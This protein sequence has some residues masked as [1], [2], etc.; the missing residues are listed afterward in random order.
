MSRA[1]SY[2]YISRTGLPVVLKVVMSCRRLACLLQVGE[3][4]LPLLTCGL[5]FCS[6]GLSTELFLLFNMC[7][8]AVS[9]ASQMRKKR[10]MMI[11]QNVK[12]SAQPVSSLS[13]IDPT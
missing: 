11:C 13:L 10:P 1:A 2:V 8:S 3:S 6:L 5:Y 7:M 12:Q 9:E 4:R